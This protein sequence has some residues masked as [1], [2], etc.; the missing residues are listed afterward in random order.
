MR[1]FFFKISR[2]LLTC[3]LI[4]FISLT[5]SIAIAL[6]EQALFAGGCFWCLEHDL[7]VLH[8]VKSVKSGFSGG[9]VINP[10]YSQ[11]S[12]KKT[13]HQETVIVL[14]DPDKISYKELLRSYW[15][16]IDPFDG[17]GQF[18]DRGDSY[19]PMIFT[20]DDDQ[21][22]QA[23]KSFQ[24]ASIELNKPIDTIKVGLKDASK[25]W[26]AEN[27]H[28]DFA[29]RNQL[30]YNFYRFSCGRDSRLEAVWGEKAR[31]N[32]PWSTKGQI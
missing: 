22:S 23:K 19:K 25:F 30:K 32:S 9:F 12:T 7:E 5:P 28:Q 21:L 2:R 18:C 3:I 13:G 31:T 4:I 24:S 1:D 20:T 10:T 8:G 15:R 27:Y 6:E 29:E 11:V 14:F 26:E 16:N 17:E